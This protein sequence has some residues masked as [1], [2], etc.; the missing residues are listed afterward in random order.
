VI[1][2]GNE[3][4]LVVPN[5]NLAEA[6]DRV[7]TISTE[8]SRAIK[9]SVAEGRLTLTAISPD[10]GR[11][12]EELDEEVS[13]AGEPLEIGFNARYIMDMSSQI[14]GDNIELAMADAGSPTLV[15]D[16]KDAS[17]LYV[18]MPMRV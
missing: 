10:A 6:V 16:P 17:T 15:R 4:L 12:V 1:P 5:K 18:L 3:K 8:K 13:Y 7:A 2:T 11:A 14:V 9:L